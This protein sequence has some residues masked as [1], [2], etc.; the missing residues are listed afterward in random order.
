MLLYT[1]ALAL[2]EV[3]NANLYFI[4]YVCILIQVYE[5]AVYEWLSQN[6]HEVG[7]HRIYKESILQN[8]TQKKCVTSY[9]ID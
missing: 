8:S 3:N 9:K 1:L 4:A 5:C 6:T 2:D 7:R